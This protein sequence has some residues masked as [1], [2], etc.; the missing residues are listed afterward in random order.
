LVFFS[1]QSI[2]IGVEQRMKKTAS[3]PYLSDRFVAEAGLLP[4]AA[5]LFQKVFANL[6]LA[7]VAQERSEENQLPQP[8]EYRL[9]QPEEHQ[10]LQ[11]A[12]LDRRPFPTP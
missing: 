8:E 9:Q 6:L 10:S 12:G 5:V 2:A 4:P 7:G 1:A 11:P 3:R